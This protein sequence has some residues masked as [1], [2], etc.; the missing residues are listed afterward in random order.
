[1]LHAHA[2]NDHVQLMQ[3]NADWH[4]LIYSASGSRYLTEFIQRLWTVFPWDTI[5]VIPGRTERSM[6]EH[7]EIMEVIAARDGV[8][9]SRLM[10]NHILSGEQSV[11]EHLKSTGRASRKEPIRGT[12]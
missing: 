2:K 11:I 1:M 3:A 10:R 8:R 6:R 9:A 5:W 7:A 12:A 4:L